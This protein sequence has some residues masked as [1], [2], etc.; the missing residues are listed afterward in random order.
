MMVER[1]KILFETICS[2][3]NL[4]DFENKEEKIL[5]LALD[6]YDVIDPFPNI[7]LDDE[8]VEIITRWM[9]SLCSS[10]A[11]SHYLKN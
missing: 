3:M 10:N 11:S 4:F 8:M 9:L 7:N 6:L 2:F 5:E 1:V